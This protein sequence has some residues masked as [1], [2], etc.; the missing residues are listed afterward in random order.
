MAATVLDIDDDTTYIG[1]E[2]LEELCRE[3]GGD[4][5]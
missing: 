2:E 4:D 5:I 3:F 1:D